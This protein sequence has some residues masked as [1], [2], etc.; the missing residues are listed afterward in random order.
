M[1]ALMLPQQQRVWEAW[2]GAEVRANYFADLVRVYRRRQLTVTWTTL[3]ASSAALGTLLTSLPAEW[4]WVRVAL[5][6][7][8]TGLSLCGVVAD[9]PRH[10]ALAAGLH[11]RWNQLGRAYERLWE[12]MYA[13]DAGQRLRQ[14]D[15]EAVALSEASTALPAHS[16]RIRKWHAHVSAHHR[17]RQPLRS[18]A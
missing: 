2:F 18:A 8:A 16:R 4:H 10:G 13:E 11:A 3:F 9:F 14:L 5:M 12:E 7:A 17:A 6:A 15:D 1:P